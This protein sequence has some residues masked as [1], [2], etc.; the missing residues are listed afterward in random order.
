MLSLHG[1]ALRYTMFAALAA[2]V[3][4]GCMTGPRWMR[5]KKVDPNSSHQ[6]GS[7]AWWAEKAQLP[8]GTRQKVYKGKVYPPF[9]RPTGEKQ[10]FSHKFHAAHYWPLPYACQDREIVANVWN[11]QVANGWTEATTL[12]EYHFDSDTNELNQPGMMHLRWI[13]EHSPDN[14]R[15]AFVQSAYDGPVDDARIAAVKTSAQKYAGA[16]T[17]PNV[18]VRHTSP[19]GR[20]AVELER[21]RQNEMDSSPQPRISAAIAGAASGGGASAGGP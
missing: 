7:D 13:M 9:P 17:I 1:R 21:I 5:Y 20:P 10:Q 19:A 6:P 11:D 14:R 2:T 18:L 12:Y 4:S 16:G 8:V 3:F 15:I